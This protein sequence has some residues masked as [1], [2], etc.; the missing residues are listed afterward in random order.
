MYDNGGVVGEYAVVPAANGGCDAWVDWHSCVFTGWSSFTDTAIQYQQCYK[1]V[2][3]HVYV[4]GTSNATNATITIAVP[5][6]STVIQIRGIAGIVDLGVGGSGRWFLNPSGTTITFNA[7]PG[8]GAFNNAGTKSVF[9]DVT[10]R[11]D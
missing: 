7:N 8:G 4:S 3:L 2:N 1:S 6:S 11:T 5:A 9:L 10:Y